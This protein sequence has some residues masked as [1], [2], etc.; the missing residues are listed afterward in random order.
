MM[1]PV[2]H[3]ARK[4]VLVLLMLSIDQ[5]H[6]HNPGVKRPDG[7]NSFPS[8]VA[9]IRLG[10]GW[11]GGQKKDE[12]NKNMSHSRKEVV[13]WGNAGGTYRF[14]GSVVSHEG[15]SGKAEGE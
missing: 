1:N 5:C 14:W 2:I 9:Q 12:V 7:R 6:V 13:C 4:I 15:Q 8:Q 3:W 10:D 11:K